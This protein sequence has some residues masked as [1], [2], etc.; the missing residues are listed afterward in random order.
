[1]NP[2]DTP[3]STG[4]ETGTNPRQL[5]REQMIRLMSLFAGIL[6]AGQWDPEIKGRK[7][8]DRLLKGEQIPPMHLR[9]WRIAREEVLANV[10]KWVRLTIENYYAFNAEMVEKDR[11]LHKL[12]PETLWTNIETVLRNIG[13]L[14]CWVDTK[15]AQTI[16]GGK[17][18]RDFWKKIFQDGVSPT[19]IRVLA[20]GLD[21]K[22]LITP[23]G[24]SKNA[25]VHPKL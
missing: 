5:E 9:A 1:M 18:N 13:D 24:V 22:E 17:P 12:L 25:P 15:L 10:L 6:F 8:E 3:L 20:R 14:P 4:L 11:V 16:F 21:L 23:K 7:L 19:G 2:I